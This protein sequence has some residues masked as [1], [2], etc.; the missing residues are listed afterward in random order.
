MATDIREVTENI[1]DE[2]VQKATGKSWSEWFAVLDAA[3][4]TTMEHKAIAT[5][6]HREQG[7]SA[8]WAQSVTGAYE[9]VR[10][11]RERHEMPNGYKV[12]VSRMVNVPLARL[13]GAWS[14][15]ER[16]TWLPDDSFTVR[17]QR[18][19]KSLWALWHD[20]TTIGVLFYAKGAEKSQVVVE[21]AK[22]ENL[23][24]AD[25]RKAF[26]GARLDVLKQRLEGT[27]TE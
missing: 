5:Y 10:G 27:D 7:C 1:S 23:K 6:L 13:Y 19:D 24:D 17:T 15:A 8:W 11:M 20:G 4:A 14:E 18:E 9:R 26:W 12:S 3:D 22:L 16:E 21:H 2:A 25:V